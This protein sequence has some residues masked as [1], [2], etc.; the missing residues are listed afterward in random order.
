MTVWMLVAFS[1]FPRAVVSTPRSLWAGERSPG[2]DVVLEGLPCTGWR[3]G[4]CLFG[5]HCRQICVVLPHV[6]GL[7]QGEAE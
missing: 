2:G 1:Q 4:L 6:I 5:C 3:L 7:W